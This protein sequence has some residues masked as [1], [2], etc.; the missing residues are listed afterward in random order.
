MQTIAL[1]AAQS[2]NLDSPDPNVAAAAFRVAVNL[3]KAN[4]HSQRTT[5]VVRRVDVSPGVP[6][7]VVC[8]CFDASGQFGVKRPEGETLAYLTAVDAIAADLAAA[9]TSLSGSDT[10]GALTSVLAALNK[11]LERL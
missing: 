8:V 2:A 7:D 4:V 3:G 6:G 5:I 9:Q 1:N 11:I 10:T